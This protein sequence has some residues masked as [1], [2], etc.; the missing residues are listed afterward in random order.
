ME[1]YETAGLYN[2][3]NVSIPSDCFRWL[4]HPLNDMRVPTEEV[5]DT[6]MARPSRLADRCTTTQLPH[7]AD[8]PDFKCPPHKS[9]PTRI[10]LARLQLESKGQR[11][12]Y[13]VSPSYTLNTK[14]ITKQ[15]HNYSN[16]LTIESSRRRTYKPSSI[17]VRT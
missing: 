15:Q 10:V 14:L 1:D 6:Q 7:S 3:G 12:K 2:C 8:S 13:Q 11:S 16:I 17:R 5:S 4:P 9:S